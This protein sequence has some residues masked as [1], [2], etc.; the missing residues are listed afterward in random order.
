MILNFPFPNRYPLIEA[1]TTILNIPIQT[2]SGLH[3]VDII[4]VV[5]VLSGLFMLSISLKKYGG[6][7][8]IVAIVAL[9]IV[10]LS[11]IYL[12]QSTFAQGIYAISYDQDESTCTFEMV[13][14]D[15]I[16]GSCAL[17]FE[18]RKNEDIEFQLEF[19]EEQWL[20]DDPPMV[21]MMNEEAPYEIAIGAKQAKTVY[22]DTLIDVSQIPLHIEGGQAFGV[23]III[24]SDDKEREL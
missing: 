4:S 18:N 23:D 13:R 10:P 24:R 11:L 9:Y 22:I 7:M 16:S 3:I 20:E 2:A 6:R 1:R 5:L 14:D 21:E 17:Q 19:Q 15:I 12:Y 8:M